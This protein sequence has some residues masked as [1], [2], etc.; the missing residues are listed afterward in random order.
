M[1]EQRKVTR[2]RTVFRGSIIFNNGNSSVNCLVRNFSETG[3]KIIVGE[4]IAFPQQFELHI[5]Q[6]GRT[7][8]A[9][10][11]W[12]NGE[13]TGVEFVNELVNDRAIPIGAGDLADQLRALEK[14]NAKLKRLVADLQLQVARSQEAG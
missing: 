10:I 3:A 2:S 11:K 9:L 14:E 12:R 6:K 13:E 4:L 1:S 5:P 7:Y 8:L